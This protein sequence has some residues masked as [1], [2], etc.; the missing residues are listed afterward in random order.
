MGFFMVESPMGRE[1]TNQNYSL[2]KHGDFA[3]AQAQAQTRW[4]GAEKWGQVTF[5]AD[6]YRCAI[7]AGN[8]T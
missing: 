4:L 2:R 7:L 6:Q 3:Q 5:P 1:T 8:G